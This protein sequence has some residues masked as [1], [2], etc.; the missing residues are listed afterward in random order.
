MQS[1][2]RCVAGNGWGGSWFGLRSVLTRILVAAV[3][4][5]TALAATAEPVV[6]YDILCEAT[7]PASQ[8]KVCDAVGEAFTPARVPATLE[9]LY[10][11]TEYEVF[12]TATA[13]RQPS[14]SVIAYA[15]LGLRPLYSND[16]VKNRTNIIL[17]SPGDVDIRDVEGDAAAAAA[18]DFLANCQPYSCVKYFKPR[19]RGPN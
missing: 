17:T 4:A 3:L 1:Q 9:R 15:G 14:G 10:P 11:P 18:R 5:S 19:K 7:D 12:V 2:F 13:M 6:R 8:R 16:W